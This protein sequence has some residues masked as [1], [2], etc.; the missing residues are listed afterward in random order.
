MYCA[1]MET[2]NITVKEGISTD[3]EIAYV[4]LG[5]DLL[6]L[7]L[8]DG[9]VGG[10]TFD[11]SWRYLILA[12]AYASQSN[13]EKTFEAL[14]ECVKYSIM[15]AEKTEGFFTSPVINRLDYGKNYSKNFKGNAC[16]VR[17]KELEWNIFDFIR[18]TPRFKEIVYLLKKYAEE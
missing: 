9:N 18:E 8:S 12:R 2:V 5:I 10:Y 7:L 3:E 14:D 1:A 16:N 6:K 11:L 13:E 4:K 17:L 15:D